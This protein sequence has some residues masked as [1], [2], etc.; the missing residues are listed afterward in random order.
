MLKNTVEHGIFNIPSD[1]Y[2]VLSDICHCERSV[3][4]GGVCFGFAKPYFN[5]FHIT[6]HFDVKKVVTK[7]TLLSHSKKTL[8]KVLLS[9]LS[10]TFGQISKNTPKNTLF[11][12][13][14]VSCERNKSNVRRFL[15]KS[16]NLTIGGR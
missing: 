10:R 9:L 14:G 6:S 7:L 13:I 4:E 15:S 12:Y 8:W 16:E 11:Y 2:K 3:K 5:L 1:G